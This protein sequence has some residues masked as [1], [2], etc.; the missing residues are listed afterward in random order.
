MVYHVSFDIDF[1]R[2]TYPGL[3]IALEG[4]DGSGKTTQAKRIAGLLERQGKKVFLTHNPTDGIIGKMIRRILNGE[5]KLSPVSFQYLYSADRQLQ[6][7][8]I[9]QHLERGETVITDRYFWSAVAYGIPGKE[10]HYSNSDMF[11]AV[12]CMLSMYH[13]HILPDYTFYLDVSL[14]T[15]MQRIRSQQGKRD[16]YEKKYRL[17]KIVYWYEWL[18]KKFPKEIIRVDAEKSLDNVTGSMMS[19]LKLKK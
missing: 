18:L 17:E 16:I 19:M 11:M 8:E 6:Q 13:Q 12:H 2:N 5:L 9:M 4:I 1:K 7:E 14:D 10:G 3:F 15:A